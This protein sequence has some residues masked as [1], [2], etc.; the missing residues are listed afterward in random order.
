VRYYKTL[1]WSNIL[2]ALDAAGW[3][4]LTF[5]ALK[6]EE[7]FIFIVLSFTFTWLF[8]TRDRMEISEADRLNN[9]E[10]SAWYASKKHLKILVFLAIFFVLGCFS[11]RLFLILPTLI[12]IVPCLFYTKKWTYKGGTFSLKGLSGVKVIL[13]AFL[14]V[15]LTVGFPI[16]ATTSDLPSFTTISSYS[17]MV[18]FFIMLQIHTND[19]RDIEGDK[20]DNIHSFAVLLGDYKARLLGLVFLGVGVYCGW[21]LFSHIA[22]LFFGFLLTLR[23][24]FYKKEKDLYWQILISLQ[25]VLAYFV[26]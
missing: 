5:K 25:G 14:W 24:V 11:L 17:L 18:G 3:T 15:L 7:D 13:V 8:Y 10:R 26:L 9:P 6:I 21:A 22:L 4:G 2:M 20:K 19:L 12:G 1:I 23:T 16:S